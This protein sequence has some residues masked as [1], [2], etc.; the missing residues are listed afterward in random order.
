MC[1]DEGYYIPRLVRYGNRI[2][3]DWCS[4]AKF[5]PCK[6][7]LY[8]LIYTSQ[9]YFLTSSIIECLQQLTNVSSFEISSV[10]V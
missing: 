2:K 6:D 7:S 3:H 1:S 5:L 10:D 8:K 9:D 4:M